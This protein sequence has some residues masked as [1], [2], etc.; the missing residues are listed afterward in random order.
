MYKVLAG[1]KT[2]RPDLR[3]FLD[4]HVGYK[5]KSSSSGQTSDSERFS[6]VHNLEH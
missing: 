3:L 2:A 6:V 1:G 4:D 5:T